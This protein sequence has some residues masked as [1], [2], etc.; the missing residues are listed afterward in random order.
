[1]PL[2]A[3]GMQHWRNFTDWLGSLPSLWVL[4]ALAFAFMLWAVID[5]LTLRTFGG[6]AN[7]TYDAMVRARI[8]TQA[9]D[10]RIVIVD[11]DESSLARMSQEF[12]RWPWPRDTLA[13]MLDAIEKQQPLAIAWDIVFSDADRLSPG[14]DKA[15]DEAARRSVHSHFSVVRLPA[16]AD[17]QSQITAAQLPGLWLSQ[18][19]ASL[20]IPSLATPPILP[21]ANPEHNAGFKPATLAVI[22]PVLPAVAAAKLGYNN[23]YPDVDGVLRRYRMSETLH[24]GSRIQSLALAVARSTKTPNAI[25]SITYYADNLAISDRFAFKK[26]DSLMVWRDKA[27][28]YPRVNFAD[29][30]AQAEGDK[31]V[32]A[33]P[34]FKSKIVLIGSTASSLH[35]IHPSPLSRQH[36]GVDMLATAI[37]NAVNGHVLAELPRTALAAIACALIAGMALWVWRHGMSALDPVLLPLPTLLL[38]I[39][40]ASLNAGGVFIDLQLAAGLAL[41]FMAVLKTWNG[42]RRNHWCSNSPQPECLMALQSAGSV[43]DVGLDRLISWLEQGAPNTR[44]IG[45]DA[46]AVWPARLRWPEALMQACLIGP[47][48]ELERLAVKPHAMI[49]SLSTI[50]HAASQNRAELWR[51]AAQLIQTTTL[52]KAE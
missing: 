42:W 52:K 13:T 26:A 48:E 7:S 6:L 27:H 23:G 22:A 19:A 18:D 11:I 37:D 38:F 20:G 4:V 49:Q 45:G 50:T 34:D 5:L 29:V 10:P 40:Y 3:S 36:A 17:A 47:R 41:I 16:E 14:G 2:A 35:D 32:K 25:E 33:A 46:T 30:F 15:F 44:L 24:D 31:P 43:A 1:M 21:I 28:A 51:Q 39:S 8:F 12:G 9:P